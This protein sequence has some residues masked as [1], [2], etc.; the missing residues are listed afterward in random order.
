IIEVRALEASYHLQARYA[1]TLA[2]YFD[3]IEDL[4]REVSKLHTAMGIYLTLQPCHPDLLHRAKN[5]LIRQKRDASTPDKYIIGYRWLLIDSDP[6]R[7][8]N[9]SSTD[10]EHAQALSH[11]RHV[12]E[13]LRTLGWPDP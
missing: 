8:S 13:Q 4:L 2:G 7:V 5:K 3:N 9:I 6:D 11:S 12:C 1:E 10:E